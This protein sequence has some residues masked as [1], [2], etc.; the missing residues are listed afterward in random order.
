MF[1]DAEIDGTVGGL[2][3]GCRGSQKN[4]TVHVELL[5]FTVR[6]LLSQILEPRL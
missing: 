1:T 3:S 5:P 4:V 2:P 6:N